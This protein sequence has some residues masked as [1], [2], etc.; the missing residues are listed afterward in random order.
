MDLMS[1]TEPIY[2][3]GAHL[4]GN[5]PL[6]IP[7]DGQGPNITSV[8]FGLVGCRQSVPHL[9]RLLGHQPTSLKHL[10]RAVGV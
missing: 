2:W 8:N 3:G 9:K 4:D 10:E 7:L 5:Y 6:S 1:P